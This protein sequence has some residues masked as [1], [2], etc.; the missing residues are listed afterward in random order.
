MNL[1]KLTAAAVLVLGCTAHGLASSQ[2]PKSNDV[3][4]PINTAP[5]T[6]ADERHLL[7]VDLDLPLKVVVKEQPAIAVYNRINALLGIEF[8]YVKGVNRESLVTVDS[9]G[10]AR[11]ALQALG[12][13]SGVRFEATGP[14]HMRV[15]QARA[16]PIRKAPK[17]P[18]PGKKN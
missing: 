6:I 2:A 10:T 12:H 4:Q 11:Q 16:G 9:K 15:L 14:R 18:P 3:M 13:A 17:A 5:G 1:S 8:G 7:R